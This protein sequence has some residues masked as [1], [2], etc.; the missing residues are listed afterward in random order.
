MDSNFVLR[1]A[2]LGLLKEQDLCGANLAMVYMSG[3][4]LAGLDF[5]NEK[6]VGACFKGEPA[7]VACLI[8]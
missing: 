8:E 6:L 1:L 3:A 4:K 2:R 7:C 5:L